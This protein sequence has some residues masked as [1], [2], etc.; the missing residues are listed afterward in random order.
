M[1]TSCVP[2][3]HCG[4]LLPGWMAGIHPDVEEGVVDRFVCFSIKQICCM[5]SV[6][7][8]VRNCGG[9]YVYKLDVMPSLG[10]S[11]RLCGAGV[12]GNVCLTL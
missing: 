2:A 6:S 10:N 3:N 1:A 5:T 9:F 7:M 4:T 11:F 8:R 12:E